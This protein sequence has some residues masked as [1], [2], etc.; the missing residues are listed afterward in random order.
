MAPHPAPAH[1][2]FSG[3]SFPQRAGCTSYSPHAAQPQAAG[4]AAYRPIELA[5]AAACKLRRLRPQAAQPEP[6]QAAACR[7][8]S[9]KLQAPPS[10]L[11]R[12][13]PTG[14]AASR[15]RI[16][17]LRRLQPVGCAASSCRLRSPEPAQ[18]TA[19]RL[20]SLKLH[21]ALEPEQ[22]AACRLRSLE[23]QACA[24]SSLRKL[25]PAA[26]P[27]PAQST[28]TACRL[29]SLKLQAAQAQAVGCAS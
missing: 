6:A 15:L 5:Q 2:F 22:A 4:Y 27:N 19:C 29:H 28:S 12:L 21:A 25:Q 10:T 26:K 23:L 18:T 3:L 9:F 8:R 1:A 20:R 17:S 13:H 24:F 16:Y 7:L 14:C 11:R